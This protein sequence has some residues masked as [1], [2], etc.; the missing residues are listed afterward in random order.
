MKNLINSI[1]TKILI[2]SPN[3]TLKIIN[4]ITIIRGGGTVVCKPR[5]PGSNLRYSL[6]D[7]FSF[8]DITAKWPNTTQIAA[9]LS[10]DGTY[11]IIYI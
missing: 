4:R 11:K 10:S 6:T 2:I 7:H 1:D 5:I 9:I 3:F 8:F